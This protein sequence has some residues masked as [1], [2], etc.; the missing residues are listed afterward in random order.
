MVW[1]ALR[2]T[3]RKHCRCTISRNRS[4]IWLD[5]PEW[6]GSG[7]TNQKPGAKTSWT[8]CFYVCFLLHER[9]AFRARL[10][11]ALLE[12]GRTTGEVAAL[13]L[14]ACLSWYRKPGSTGRMRMATAEETSSSAGPEHYA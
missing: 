9:V 7:Q 5:P 11:R 12:R 14:D 8:N 2:L 1:E 4:G 13:L 6:S 10:A 3:C